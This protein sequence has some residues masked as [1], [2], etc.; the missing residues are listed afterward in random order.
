MYL[1]EEFIFYHCTQ[2]KLR[3]NMFMCVVDFHIKD[4]MTIL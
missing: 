3:K 4:V 2:L 1:N